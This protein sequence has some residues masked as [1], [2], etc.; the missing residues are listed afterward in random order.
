MA[1]GH[2][3]NRSTGP[4]PEKRSAASSTTALGKLRRSRGETAGVAESAP[5]GPR[6]LWLVQHPAS[7]STDHDRGGAKARAC[8]P[9]RPVDPAQRCEEETPSGRS[10]R[11]ERPVHSHSKSHLRSARPS[12]SVS[13][14]ATELRSSCHGGFRIGRIRSTT[15]PSRLKA[16]KVCRP[17]SKDRSIRRSRPSSDRSP[18]SSS[19]RK[20]SE[21]RASNSR[22]I[23]SVAV[24]SVENRTPAAAS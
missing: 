12:R 10:S 17:R 15:K 20:T 8:G 13:D 22:S 3:S 16:L 7:F 24:T 1:L 23:S 14:S 5:P 19:A 18:M 4:A 6:R 11:R 2:H 21:A 9:R